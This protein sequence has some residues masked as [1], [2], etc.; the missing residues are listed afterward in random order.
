[1]RACPPRQLASPL[2]H[3]HLLA[4]AAAAA[5]PSPALPPLPGRGFRA[6][7]HSDVR[8]TLPC[9]CARALCSRTDEAAEELQALLDEELLAGIPLLVFANKQ[10]L[11]NAMTAGELMKELEL[12]NDKSRWTHVQACSAKTGD[13]LN[14]GLEQLLKQVKGASS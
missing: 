3:K 9:P 2:A 11:L 7:P 6:P 4:A 12:T 5:P 1:M 10:D 14:E 8:G 13:G